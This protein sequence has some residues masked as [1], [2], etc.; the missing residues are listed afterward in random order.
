MAFIPIRRAFIASRLV[1]Q[2]AM[3]AHGSFGAAIV[4]VESGDRE[5]TTAAS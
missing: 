2:K 5:G 1:R 3:A 4:I